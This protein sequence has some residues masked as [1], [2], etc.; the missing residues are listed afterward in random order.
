MMD[1]FCSETFCESAKCL[2]LR[3]VIRV[4]AN[5]RLRKKLKMCNICAFSVFVMKPKLTLPAFYDLR[6]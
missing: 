1:Y 6:P 5:Y 4:S 2:C 3:H